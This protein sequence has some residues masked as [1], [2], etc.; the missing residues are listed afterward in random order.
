[1]VLI[2]IVVPVYNSGKYLQTCVDS[3][4]AQTYT[5]FE[6]ILVDDGS[7]DESG[8][9]CDSYAQADDRIKVFHQKNSGVSIARN[10]GIKNS[11]GEWISFIDSD[12]YI[13]SSYFEHL[14]CYC[15]NDWIIG[16]YK[17]K[18]YCIEPSTASYS[19]NNFIEFWNT[20][21]HRLYS[22][23]PWGKLYKREIIENNN[24][25][26]DSSIRLGE[27]LVFNLSYIRYCRSIQVISD[28]QYVYTTSSI[29]SERYDLSESELIYIVK[30]IKL[31]TSVLNQ[32]KGIKC[33]SKLILKT[34][35]GTYPLRL[36]F[37][38]NNIHDYF[39]IYKDCFEGA[40][41]MQLLEDEICSPIK[42]GIRYFKE[43]A[44]Q[45]RYNECLDLMEKMYVIFYKDFSTLHYGHYYDK[46]IA[47]LIKN[48]MY[49]T[50][51]FIGSLI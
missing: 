6:L 30:K 37:Q 7:S 20:H 40:S 45:K 9:I 35:I 1:M 49:H 47:L 8:S 29:A 39:L 26:F 18:T 3:I 33:S 15:S 23:V 14:L 32:T 50:V 4:L 38:N 2:S 41:R 10:V 16:G 48:K 44:R 36:I 17:T 11:R 27:D 12:D 25:N 42:R 22:T 31:L 28:P 13:E 21:F 24:L 46:L 5:N 51:Y 34:I 43:L 19:N